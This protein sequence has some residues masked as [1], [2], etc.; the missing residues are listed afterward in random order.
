M[1]SRVTWFLLSIAL[2]AA[3]PR[4]ALAQQLDTPDTTAI[5]RQISTENHGGQFHV[6]ALAIYRFPGIPERIVV[7][8]VGGD[9]TRILAYALGTR[10]RSAPFYDSGYPND[11]CGGP[12]ISV[13]DVR[14]QYLLDRPLVVLEERRSN[15][16]CVGEAT[17]VRVTS[18]FYDVRR[19][20]R[21]VLEVETEV[22]DYGNPE[23]APARVPVYRHTLLFPNGCAVLETTCHYLSA[24]TLSSDRH[25]RPRYIGYSWNADSTALIGMPSGLR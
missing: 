9:L 5:I 1:S 22:I 19:G 25:Y 20:L 15:P 6:A 16:G 8:R 4:D 12:D 17:T 23:D 11:E 3:S 21:K 24:F 10:V 2:V 14:L 13:T 7:V 18:R